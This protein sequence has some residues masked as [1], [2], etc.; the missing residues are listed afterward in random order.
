MKK[1]PRIRY[2]YI[3]TV[4]ETKDNTLIRKDTLSVCSSLRKATIGLHAAIYDE[5]TNRTNAKHPVP[6]DFSMEKNEARFVDKKDGHTVSYRITKY[7]ED[8]Q[9]FSNAEN[10]F[11]FKP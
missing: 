6:Y 11:D 1:L 10:M 3:V 2:K 8:S 9:P 4:T 5:T 7:Q